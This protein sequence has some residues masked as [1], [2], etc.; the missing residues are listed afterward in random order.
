MAASG[1]KERYINRGSNV[2]SNHASELAV[3][4]ND[5]G[6]GM[7]IRRL[8]DIYS[9]I[10][11]DEIQD[12]AGYDIDLI[13]L[14]MESGISVSCVGDYKQATYKTNTGNKNKK[15]SGKH[16]GGFC[17]LV[18]K[19]RLAFIETNLSTRRFN[20]N[21][22]H[23]ANK[24]FPAGDE[25]T[26][27]IEARECDDGVFL[28]QRSD[29]TYYFNH[30]QPTV[31]KYDIKTT[32]N[33]WQSFNFGGCKG[34]TFDRVLVFPN[35]VLTEY[36]QKGKSISAPEKYYVG[37]TRPRYSLAFVVD[38]FPEKEHIYQE[39]DLTLAGRCIKAM[40]YILDEQ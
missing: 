27:N 23:F 13:L 34:M 28:I 18:S 24:L 40:K 9:H 15:A 36:I 38:T 2:M 11:I 1:Q 6:K 16:I 29:V 20:K 32:T 26:S 10:Y 19:Q 14:L 30:Y 31:L 17:D 25:M 22:C 3:Y 5:A 21:I 33:E 4:L 39:I 7:P 35:G 12:M 8:A 37:V